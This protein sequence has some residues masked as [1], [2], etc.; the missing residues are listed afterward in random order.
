[1]ITLAL[2]AEDRAAVEVVQHLT[3]QVL[4]EVEWMVAEGLPQV[5]CWQQ[6]HGE[7]WLPWKKV[8]ERARQTLG[9][10]FRVSG[11]FDGKPGAEDALAVRKVIALM[12][13]EGEPTVLILARDIDHTN[14]RTGFSQALEET[15]PSRLPCRVVLALA[16]PEVEAWLVCVWKPEDRAGQVAHEAL[17]QSL[18]FDPVALSHEL[19][20][21][22]S[23]K[24]DAKAVMGHL[25]AVGPSPRERFL[26]MK[27]E[28]LLNHGEDNGL[29]QFV[30]SL[31]SA[32][33]AELR[34]RKR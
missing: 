8:A 22:S 21:T 3:D 34:Y 14:R 24:R 33:H 29:A 19:T 26:A 17:R 30:H 27:C 7:D 4:L 9:R 31:R 32:L 5:R 12:R 11:H 6:F 1:M 15:G 25:A 13:E 2:V 20:S 10:T 23:S 16:Q 28:D 18:G